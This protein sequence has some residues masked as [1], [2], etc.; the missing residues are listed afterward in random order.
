M[1]HI[2][3]YSRENLRNKCPYDVF[4]FLYGRKFWIF[5]G[6][7]K[8]LPRMCH[9]IDP[10]F[11]RRTA[12]RVDK[13]SINCQINLAALQKMEETVPMTLRERRCLRKWVYKGN[14]VESNPWNYMDSARMP[15]NYLQAFRIRFD[16]SS[17]S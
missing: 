6:A 8:F 14:E 11:T 2:N 5:L 16:Y 1:D 3:S 4:S 7:T 10:F 17:G 15:L 13:D 12:M 9:S